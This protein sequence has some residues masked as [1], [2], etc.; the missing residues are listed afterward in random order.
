MARRTGQR[1]AVPIG[2]AA[3]LAATAFLAVPGKSADPV[4]LRGHL[5]DVFMAAFTPD[6]RR[7][8]TASADETARLWDAADGTEVRRFTGHTGP[9]SCLAVSGDGRTLVTGGQDNA[10]RVWG[11]PLSGP[12]VAIAA[13]PSAATTLLT[14]PD[15]RTAITAG[16]KEV[17]L[18]SLDT[19][20]AMPVPPPP[21]VVRAAHE[22]NVVAAAATA[23]GSGFATAD[24]GGR[25]L[26]WSPLLDE[27]LGSLGLHTGGIAAVAFHPDGQ[28]LV[29]TGLDGT[30]RIWTLPAQPPRV[31][32]AAATAVR[33]LVPVANQPQA[34]VLHDAGVRIVDTQSLQTVREFPASPVPGTA[35][36]LAPDGASMAVADEQGGV[37]L[38]QI[39]DAADRGRL[40]GHAGPVHDVAFLPD[41]TSLVTAGADGTVRHWRLPAAP[42]PLAGHTGIVQAMATAATG[43]WF[44]S[45]A[46]DKTVRMWGPTGQPVRTIGTHAASVQ[47]V[48]IAPD[49]T[50]IVTGDA[51]GTLA[52]WAAADG[53]TQ[54]GVVAHR[55]GIRC[56]RHAPATTSVWSAGGDGTLKRWKLPLVPPLALAGHTQPVR[57]AATSADG[58]VVV[59]GGQDQTVRIWD[60]LTGQAVRSL[61][62]QAAGA[63][64]A[65][66]V[67]PDGSLVA[68]VTDTGSLR[69]W[70]SGDGAAVLERT[71]PGG[72]GCDVAFLA[73]THLATLCQDNV[74]RIWDLAAAPDAAASAELPAPD[75]ETRLLAAHPAGTTL[76]A[77]GAGRRLAVWQLTGGRPADAPAV[78]IA[79][80]PARVTDIGFAADGMRFAAACDDGRVAV[81]DAAQ[82]AT[83]DAP[84]RQAWM[85]PAPVRGLAIDAVANR[86]VVAA[87]D[88]ATAYDMATGREAERWLPAMPQAVAATTTAGRPLTAGPDGT[89]RIWTPALERLV[90]TGDTPTDAVASFAVLPDDAGLLALGTGSAGLR[91]WK[92]DGTPQPPLWS[93]FTPM[94]LAVAADGS[95]LAAVDAAGAVRIWR[96]VDGGS[97][98]LGPV[99]QGTTTLAFTSDTS[100][101]LAADASGRIQAFAVADGRLVESITLPAPASCLAVTGTDGRLWASFGATP[102]GSLVRRSWLTTW[103]TGGAAHAVAVDPTGG[104]LFAG[105]A[106]GAVWQI[107]IAGGAVERTLAATD[108]A[109]YDV[110]L[111][112]TSGLLAAGGADGTRLWSLADGTLARHLPSAAPVRRVAFGAAAAKRLAT[113][114]ASGAIELWD[115]GSGAPVETSA[116]HRDG[117]AVVRYAADGQTLLSAGRDG[118]LAVWRGAAA[119]SFAVATV[120]VRGL[121]PGGGNQMHVADDDGRV[122]TIDVTNGAVVRTLGAGLV[123]PI[124]LAVRPDQQRL[125][126]GSG[127]GSVRLINPAN[128]AELQSLDAG[129]AVTALAWRA[130]GQRL[131][132]ATAA[133]GD[134]PPRIT[135]FAPPATPPQPP[136]GRELERQDAAPATA[137]VVRLAFDRDGRDVWGVQADGVLARWTLA[138]TAPLFKL[139]HGGPVLAVVISRDGQSIVSGGADN[140]VRVWDAATGQQRAQMAGHTAAVHALAF[141]PDE[142][143]VVSAAADRTLRLW[144][145]GGGRQLKQVATTEETVYSIAVHPAGQTVAAGGADR[146]VHL[147]NLVSGAVERTLAGHGDFV[148]SVAFNPAGTTLLSYGYA[149]ELR[150]WGLAAATP[151]LDLRVGRIGNSAAFDAK[152][153]RV[154]V[155]NG[156]RTASIIEVPAHAR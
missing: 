54:G 155:A 29:S 150:I 50:S 53:A 33:D 98:S 83:T 34:V 25:I 101:L 48:A 18:W 143:L 153:E 114:D 146:A 79:V 71:L 65:V 123:P 76:V 78:P 116:L 36:A 139:D 3:M 22:A 32:A 140:T 60:P 154:V 132:A 37:R 85:H 124:A 39:A 129:G 97:S 73:A 26:L 108:A 151:V 82:L 90:P 8:V 68:A 133:A 47:A 115:V 1:V 104:R 95:R 74:V 138:A 109:V 99:G 70:K 84:P 92:T 86:L 12:R 15:G 6:G 134:R 80:G 35:L 142:A 10:V 40:A 148:H 64:A 38:L 30:L 125:A 19:L 103:E 93:D 43:E 56:L 27:P 5:A 17:R 21:A 117:P 24:A 121:V 42:L 112:A 144:D 127:D 107:A 145:V 61:G 137:D 46:D 87:D 119:A 81:W 51:A 4:V 62:G 28:R 149:G 118:R 94:R 69:I 55:G 58:R 20:T 49:A 63:V 91:R 59:T 135:G 11:L 126:V 67:T 120:P 7:V 122:V 23:D 128:A 96:S 88:G 77:S 44:V 75:A 66:A 45:A 147:V 14:L 130:D 16:G 9:V 141:T 105:L 111:E 31:A 57:A 41:G 2:W 152:G 110:A 106:T 102:A 131:A 52:V 72:A 100:Q 136:P 89:P 13:H 113:A 156:D